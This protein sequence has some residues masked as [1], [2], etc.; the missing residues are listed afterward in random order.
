MVKLRGASTRDSAVLARLVTELGYDSTEGQLE[1]RL[2]SILG[3]KDR[4]LIVAEID[5]VVVGAVLLALASALHHD[6]LF[7]RIDTVVVSESHRG[8]KIGSLLVKEA[9][10]VARLAGA[11]RIV[12]TSASHREIAHAF[13]VSNGFEVTGIRFVKML[14]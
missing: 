8:Q 7:M 4:R 10:S 1:D 13:Y 11:H 12:V 5:G 6:G 3:Q 14:E 2:V 9:E